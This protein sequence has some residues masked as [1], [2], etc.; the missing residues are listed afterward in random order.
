MFN[1]LRREGVVLLVLV[2]ALI[3]RIEAEPITNA[4]RLSFNLS[5]GAISSFDVT[6]TLKSDRSRHSKYPLKTG[7]GMGVGFDFRLYRPISLGI[8]VD[9][10]SSPIQVYNFFGSRIDT[11]QGF[12]AGS[13]MLKSVV[14]LSGKRLAV[15]L[16]LGPGFGYLS[17]ILFEGWTHLTV[18]R[19]SVELM[20]RPFGIQV[21]RF[22]VV[23]G[24][25]DKYDI[26][27]KP[28]YMFRA[29]IG[30]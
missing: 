13:L 24:S 23:S 8:A 17:E 18:M 6:S 2:P 21:V 20:L 27:T 29:G 10:G 9:Q 5:L 28:F 16:G 7:F 30:F 25:N 3:S 15:R 4:P 12:S 1:C 14:P 11:R 26:T 22:D 19:Y